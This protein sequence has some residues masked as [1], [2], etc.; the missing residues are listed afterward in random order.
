MTRDQLI[1]FASQFGY[2]ISATQ[3]EDWHKFGLLPNPIRV[4]NG[5]P[6]SY[7]EYPDYAKE[8]LHLILTSTE[9]RRDLKG[10]LIDIWFRGA[11][12]DFEKLIAVLE[13]PIIKMEK[14][15]G[16]P[17]R[18]LQKAVK[19]LSVSNI[20]KANKV[21]PFPFASISDNLTTVNVLAQS[22]SP[23]GKSD[24]WQLN[25]LEDTEESTASIAYRVSGID[26]LPIV[27]GLSP[28]E[29]WDDIF[30]HINLR[31]IRK[32]LL[33]VNNADLETIQK[34]APIV[35]K[36]FKDLMYIMSVNQSGF[37]FLKLAASRFISPYTM[38]CL[39]TSLLISLYHNKDT[40]T[41]VIDTVEDFSK[42]LHTLDALTHYINHMKKHPLLRKRKLWNEFF[43]NCNEDSLTSLQIHE[44][45]FMSANPDFKRIL[46][47]FLNNNV[48]ND[49]KIN[50]PS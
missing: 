39:I 18:F 32:S 43:S 4:P 22:I 35:L 40:R 25:G 1:K 49:L 50:D 42:N 7:Y 9:S 31:K 38:R 24:I 45:L 48:T 21:K 15:L 30:K 33:E 5:V 36:T 12:V 46:S 8:N 29:L 34:M 3:I 37:N 28:E 16:Q 2:K 6:G 41:Q 17:G 27:F 19:L 47:V 10:I 14:H 44:E 11:R 23:A 13:V 26:N 20:K